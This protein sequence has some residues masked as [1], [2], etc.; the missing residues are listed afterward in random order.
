MNKNKIIFSIIWWIILILIFWWVFLMNSSSKNSAKKSE[1]EGNFV[2]WTYG[3]DQTKIDEVIKEFKSKAKTYE[4]K[5]IK[6][7]NF[8]NYTDYK[9]ALL[10]SIVLW[11]SPDIF[12]LSNF[13]K[14]YLE[15]NVLW[16]NPNAINPKDF[17][18]NYKTF[19]VD[20]L[21]KETTDEDWKKVEFV[22]WIPLWYE[23]LG[24]FYNRKFN[25]KPSDLES[26]AWVNTIIDDI[27][28]RY[29]DIVPLWIMNSSIDNNSDVM[30][31]FFMLSESSPLSLDKVSELSEKEAFWK[32][33]S[34]FNQVNSSN[35]VDNF[36]EAQYSDSENTWKTNLELFSEWNEAMIIGYPSMINSLD[37]VWFNSSFLFAE[38][39][40]HY[41]SW[42]WKTLVKY[43]YFVVNKNTKDE[44]LAF[45]FLTYLSS[46]EW[47][48]L[49]LNK[50]TYLLPAIVTLEQDKLGEK[51]HP[52]YNLTLSDFYKGGDDSLLSSFDKWIEILYDEEL[53]KIVKDNNNYLE[54]F[55]KL[56]KVISCRYK[57]LYSLEGLSIDCEK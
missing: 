22:M 30:T 41:F 44:T 27:K 26:L 15:N 13:E 36:P 57:K 5:S 42:N 12:L 4:D 9:E 24:F 32:Y 8:E 23:T 21:L 39:F 3:L 20:D 53:N 55:K 50:F 56:Q 1:T 47:S 6:V 33:Q 2:I 45:D 31:Q 40:P 16:I 54:K 49:F 35:S 48:K 11:K 14:S 7:E 38:P 34:Y 19:F 10:A 17:R 52:S 28:S 43:S 51:I 37:E 46:E 18:K 29:P 25:V